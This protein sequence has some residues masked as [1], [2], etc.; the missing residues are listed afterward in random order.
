MTRIFACSCKHAYQDERFGH[1]MRA[2]NKCVS[3]AASGTKWRCTVCQR[4]HVV[5]KERENELMEKAV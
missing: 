2:F 4:A 5:H 3:S 1:G